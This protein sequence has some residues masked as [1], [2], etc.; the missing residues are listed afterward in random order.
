MV[1]YRTPDGT[2]V[3]VITLSLT[4]PGS[5]RNH[6]YRL[7]PEGSRD[8]QWLV[9]K[10]PGGTVRAYVRTVEDLA[11]VGVGLEDLEEA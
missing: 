3:E 4:S 1:K 8:G 6:D 9:V 5:P 2:T 7:F 11:D 10:N